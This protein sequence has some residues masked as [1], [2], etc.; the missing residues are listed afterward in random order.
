MF[1]QVR[2]PKCASRFAAVVGEL[3]NA[4][5]RVY[6]SHAM[7]VSSRFHESRSIN[8]P[9]CVCRRVLKGGFRNW[10]SKLAQHPHFASYVEKFD[11]QKYESEY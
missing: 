8:K 4:K 3:P 5:C 2:G 7:F 1:S 10:V 11:Q 9:F 6:A